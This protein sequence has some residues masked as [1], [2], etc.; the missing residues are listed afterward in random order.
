MVVWDTQESAVLYILN[1]KDKV[2]KI[3]IKIN[4]SNKGE[5]YI[6]TSSKITTQAVNRLIKGSKY[7]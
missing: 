4:Y 5:N 1:T 7:E 2:Y 6:K 3:I